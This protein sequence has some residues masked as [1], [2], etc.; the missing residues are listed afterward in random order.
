MIP[1]LVVLA[2][3]LGVSFLCSILEAVF[4]SISHSWVAV[5]VDREEPAGRILQRMRE[6]IDEPIAA[7][8]T[9]NTIAHTVGAA[10]GGAMAYDVFGERWIAVFSAVLTLAILIFSEIIPKTLGTRYWQEL[11]RPA[12]YV[13]RGMIVL[14]KPV[15]V[16]LSALN[17][18]ISPT[19][20]KR[21]T[22]S[23]AELEVLAEIG[24]REGT[25][26]REEW[27]VVSNVMNLDALRV[28][29]VMTPR[30]DVDGIRAD[31][32]LADAKAAMVASGHSRLPVYRT[33]LDDIT[34]MVIARDLQRAEIE[35]IGDLGSILRPVRY[36]PA[37]KSVED[38]LREMRRDRVKLTVV[39]DEYG[40][41]AGI[42]TLE[43]L[44]EEIVGDIEDEHEDG[45]ED[46]VRTAAGAWGIDARV[47]LRELAER[48]DLDLP[49]D[50]YATVAG[51]LFGELA[52]VGS[53][54]DEVRHGPAVFRIE[55]MDGVRVKRVSL[56]LP[57]R[58]ARRP[59]T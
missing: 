48:F 6:H 31:A 9:L 57:A 14:L 11:A 51:F 3:S 36:T 10:V 41:T 32:T 39:V 58:T 43:D 54:G 13:L 53:V 4:L 37:S 40:G 24:R 19:G 8:L 55:A 1:L 47:P 50:R 38:L 33:S 23:R 44:L 15:L 12:A 56:R 59:E 7:I 42:V 16:P 2:V 27:Q 25:I 22:V 26:D 29:D 46:I 20:E 5:L 49:V 45:P 17:R 34:G 35:G 52:R 18:W 30:T 28:E 21:P